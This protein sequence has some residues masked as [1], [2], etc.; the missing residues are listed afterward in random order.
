MS[1]IKI[2]VC[3]GAAA[4]ATIAAT[5]C[6]ETWRNGT[7]EGL[8]MVNDTVGLDHVTVTLKGEGRQ[9]ASCSVLEGDLCKTF[10]GAYGWADVP[11]GQ[12]TVTISD[13]PAGVRFDTTTKSAVIASSGQWVNV[14]FWGSY[15]EP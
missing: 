4:L 14:S 8:V 9:G 15:I 13:I 10:L 1:K 12:Y 6:D 2:A 3:I 7:I 11:A 5:S